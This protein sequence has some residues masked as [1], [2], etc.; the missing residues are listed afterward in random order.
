MR[1]PG[2]D[3][4]LAAGLLVG[5]GIVHARDDLKGFRHGVDRDR[6]PDLNSLVAELAPG[7]RYDPASWQRATIR[8]SA[9]GICGRATLDALRAHAPAA[10]RPR[11]GWIGDA[12]LR[13]VPAALEAA[14]EVFSTTGGLHAAAWFDR[15]G[16]VREVREDVGR[17]NAVDKLIGA[18]FLA[19]RAPSEGGGL[20]V[21]GRAGYEILQKAAMAG[22]P[23]V[24]AL[25][26]PTSLAVELAL[27]F[28]ITLVG[29][30]RQDG[31]NVYAA[32]GRISPRRPR[33]GITITRR[34]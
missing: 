5:E 17:H 34:A 12:A 25:G 20:V 7:I 31:Y 16:A 1:T 9:C 11:A 13:G 24:A 23:F 26:A 33:K 27:E 14:Q 19:G 6:H 28:G 10:P 3:E 22:I 15:D 2:R 30:L 29:F 32:P 21:S 4:E 18:A 8:S